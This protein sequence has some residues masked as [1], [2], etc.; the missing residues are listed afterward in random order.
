MH[1]PEDPPSSEVTILDARTGAQLLRLTNDEQS[2]SPVWSPKGDEIVMNVAP[3]QSAVVG[4]STA[5]R[6][7]F[8]P[9]S[10][11]PRQGRTEGDPRT[12][13]RNVDMMPDGQRVIGV[14][15]QSGLENAVQ[16]QVTVI[17]NWF[18]EL[19]QRVPAE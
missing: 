3:T 18:D 15:P 10:D 6:V 16:R 17:L 12:A 19:R 4:I 14:A 2:F 9:P 1:L 13:R 7:A 11:F 5:P 8:G